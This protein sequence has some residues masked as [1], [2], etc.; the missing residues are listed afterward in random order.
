[1]LIRHRGRRPVVDPTAYVAPTA[2]LAGDVSV[3]PRA[4][5]MYGAVLDAEDERI[6]VGECSVICENAVL[7]GAVTLDDHVFVGPR[8]TLLG[9]AVSRCAYL[10]TGATV[11]QEAVLGP[12]SV[13]AIGAAVHARG[14]LPE[15]FFVP[16]NTVFVG[17]RVYAP[18]DPE[19][20][21]AIKAVGFTAVAFGVE[22]AWEDRIARYER[23]AEV[24]SAQFGAHADDEVVG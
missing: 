22:M 10:A 17:G 13:V 20:P 6:E 9:C 7:R 15:E 11:L 16:P 5:V 4:R 12:G 18:G 1:M 24:R 19:L 2:V 14:R 3:G 8:A 21:Q 23:V